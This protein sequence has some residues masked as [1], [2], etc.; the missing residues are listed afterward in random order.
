MRGI[1]RKVTAAVLA[2]L[3]FGATLGMSLRDWQYFE[4]SGS[5][6]TLVAIVLV[7]RD[8]VSS[9]GDME[10]VYGG[11]FESLR[12]QME[13]ARRRGLIAGSMYDGQCQ[14]LDEMTVDL[15]AM[16]TLLRKRIRTMEAVAF[17]LG[18]I[19]WGYGAPI[20]SLVW[21]FSDG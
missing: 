8:L 17:G 1:E 7:W 9:V 13:D 10:K 11:L 6:V 20:A 16:N 3:L 21:R 5:L 14:S 4:R 2:S 12:R 15:V 18:T 19:V